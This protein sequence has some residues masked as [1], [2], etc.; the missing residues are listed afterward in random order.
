MPNPMYRQIAEDLRE[1][2]GPN[3]RLPPPQYELGGDGQ[4]SRLPRWN[5]TT[6]PFLSS[7]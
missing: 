4:D 1:Q 6:L 2:V 7:G 3:G 5:R